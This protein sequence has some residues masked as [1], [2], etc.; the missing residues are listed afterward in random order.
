M[1]LGEKLRQAREDRGISL[2]EV[3]E[4]TRISPLYLESIENDDYRNLPGGI[5]NKGFIKTFAKYVGVDEQEAMTDYGQIVSAS[6][7]E[8]DEK[9]LRLYKPEVLTD[10]TSGSSMIPTIIV[11]V[12]ILA[13]MTAGILFLVN[14][15]RQPADP[16]AANSAATPATNSNAVPSGSNTSATDPTAPAMGSANFEIKTTTALVKIVATVDSEPA[17]PSNLAAGSSVTFT[18]KESL[19]LNYSR[20]NFDKVQLT[21]NGKTI[22]LP[23]APLAPA[24]RDRIIVTINKDNLAQIWTSGT[25]SSEVPPATTD[26]NANVAAPPAATTAPVQQRPTPLPPKP[27]NVAANT[28]ANTAVKPPANTAKPPTMT[29]PKP[30]PKP[31]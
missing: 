17:K 5:F 23:S 11:A 15:L 30:T 14:Y 4:Q 24:D 19:T 25:V 16:V 31:Q 26:A 12:V 13:L 22:S 9:E 2:S 10:D 3:A 28:A 1:T 8:L 6:S 18:P 27:A 29:G 20:W 7:G 21:I